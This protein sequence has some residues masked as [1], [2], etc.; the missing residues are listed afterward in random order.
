MRSFR[1]I[2]SYTIVLFLIIFIA[3]PSVHS[4]ADNYYYQVKDGVKHYTNIKPGDNGFT[5]VRS[6]WIPSPYS[7]TKSS[8]PSL[9]ATEY[10]D[11]Y[12]D[13]INYASQVYDLDPDLVKAMIKVESD[14]YHRAVSPKGAMGV[15]QLMPGTAEII[16]VKRPF[17]PSE[18]IMGGSKYLRKLLDMFNG[19]RTLALA[20]YNAGENA[21][22]KYGYSVPP[23]RE[24][25][26]Y[27]TK[28]FR[29]YNHIKNS[30]D[31]I[32]RGVVAKRDP[33]SIM[34]KK[35]EEKKNDNRELSKVS[36]KESLSEDGQEFVR[37]TRK[38]KVIVESVKYVDVEDKSDSK[39]KSS[40]TNKKI[41]TNGD[42]TVQI[43]SFD[44]I[45]SARELESSLKSKTLPAYIKVA[46]IPGKGTWYR[47]RVGGFNSKSEAVSY[48]EYLK[49][50][51]PYINGAFVTAN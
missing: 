30:S 23:Y 26:Q 49:S 47:V 8:Y 33:G 48:A 10:S 25:Q 13:Y 1:G 5:K 24:T 34:E 17:D 37:K 43:A 29:H 46:Q 12:D 22:I 4:F 16:G 38:S 44:E 2:D 27:V 32:N 42:Y 21:V 41:D 20:G 15:M 18:N 36:Y 19:N 45:D 40:F 6:G 28:V 9:G 11:K 39:A 14:F 51:Q 31:S 7:R 50:E 35:E 3:C